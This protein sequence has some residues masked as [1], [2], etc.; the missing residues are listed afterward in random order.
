MKRDEI[1]VHDIYICLYIP[2]R[3]PVPGVRYAFIPA[4]TTLFDIYLSI[5]LLY[6]GYNVTDSLTP[7]IITLIPI[8]P[9][10]NLKSTYD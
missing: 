10:T 2:K 3:C 4:Q 7:N 5:T 6:Q 8:S 9:G 1:Y